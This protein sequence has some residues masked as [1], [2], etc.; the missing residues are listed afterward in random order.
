LSP[1]KHL[2]A[3]SVSGAIFYL[4]SKSFW[5]SLVCFLSGIFIDLDHFCD[6][7]LHYKRFAINL[8]EFYFNCIDLK[9]DKLY[10]FL[11]SWELVL[12]VWF[13]III[14]KLDLIWIALAVGVTLHTLLDA[15]GNNASSFSY[16][17]IYRMLK[18][19]RAE[20]LFRNE[21]F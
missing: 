6:F 10:L 11:H 13:L 3:S 4:Y 18:G 9:F 21:K 20:L 7:Y 19:F 14:L 2:V 17:F 12:T 16:F 5:P 1:V 8:R 15:L